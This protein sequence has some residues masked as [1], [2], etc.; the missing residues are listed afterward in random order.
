LWSIV[1]WA[2]SAQIILVLE[3]LKFSKIKLFVKENEESFG[4]LLGIFHLEEWN[5]QNKDM[6]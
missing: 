2:A 6:C 3:M 5:L 4:N 1:L